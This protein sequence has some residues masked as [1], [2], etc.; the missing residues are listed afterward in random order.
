MDS[1][2]VYSNSEMTVMDA[3][4]NRRSIRHFTNQEVSQQDIETILHAGFCAPS[5]RRA[6]PWHFVIVRDKDRMMQFSELNPY[7]KMFAEANFAIAV[8]G[9]EE[10][11]KDMDYLYEDC[12]AAIQNMLLTIH[13]LGLGAVWCGMKRDSEYYHNLANLCLLPEKIVPIGLIAVGYPAEEKVGRDRY[14]EDKVHYE[15]W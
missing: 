12:S 10:A 2:R 13:A 14:E 8:C 3:I 7:T 9:D 11:Q 4:F 15:K 1:N 5:A 6:R